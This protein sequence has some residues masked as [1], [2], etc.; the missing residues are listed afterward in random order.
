VVRWISL[1]SVTGRPAEDFKSAA[2][3]L[4]WFL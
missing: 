1:C 4:D 2:T 3:S